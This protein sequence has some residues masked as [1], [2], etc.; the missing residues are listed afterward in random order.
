[1][2]LFSVF[3]LVSLAAIIF[4]AVQYQRNPEHTKLPFG[5]TDLSSVQTQLAKLPEE[6]RKLVESYVKRS[7]GDV[8]PAQFADP[9]NPLTARTFA[10]A[11]ELEKQWQVKM[12]LAKVK[13]DELKLQRLAKLEPL[14]ALVNASVI[15]AEIITVNEYQKRLNP[16]GFHQPNTTPT[17]VSTILIKNLSNQRIVGMQGSLKAH[18]RDAFLPLDICWIDL[19]LQ[20]E[21]AAGGSLEISCADQHGG[22]S[23][24]QKAFVEDDNDRFEVEWVPKTI[25]FDDGR[26]INSAVDW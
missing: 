15:K 21:I 19:G 8:L 24:Q 25:K 22:A 1:M 10:E 17:F 12:A 20:R 4:L 5:S 16:D 6:D 3:K 26:E 23:E 14:L 7:N 13:S 9:D 18:D 11:I 2:N